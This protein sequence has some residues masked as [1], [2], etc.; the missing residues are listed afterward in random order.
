MPGRQA[1]G[2]S[3]LAQPKAK[4]GPKKSKSRAQTNALN[5]FNIAQERFPTKDKRTPRARELDAEIEKK[6]GREEDDEEDEEEEEG[7]KRKKA[8]A[9]RGAT[10]DGD[11]EFG[12]DSEG[13]EWQLGGM[14]NDD[15]DSEIES[16]DAFG[17]SDNE[18]FQGYAFRGSKSGQRK[19]D[20]SEDSDDGNDDQG[21]TLGED[22][23]DLATALDQFEEESEEEPEG[24][25]EEEDS[26]SGEE[27]DSDESDE[28]EGLDDSDEEAD[29]AKLEEL[30]GLISGFGGEEDDGE[31]A[32][33]SSGQQKIDLGDLGLSGLN[34]PFMKQSVK[35]MKK[36]SKEKRPGSTKKLEV[37][38]SR[39]EQGRIDR[40]AAYEKTN[41][42]L[43]RWTETVKQNRRAE[44]LVFPLPQNSE[45]AGLDRTELQPLSL[46][47]AANELEATIMGIME[48]S[49]LSL[50]KEKKPKKQEF[51]EEG[52]LLTRKQALEKKRIERELHSREAKRAARIKKIKS[53]AYHRVHRKQKERDEMATREAMA[54][55]G[56]IDSEE[57]REAQDRRRAL[58]R[59]GQ[60]H[61]DSKWAKMGSKAK[62]AVWDDDFRAGLTE[63]ARKDEDLRRRKEGKS[64]R[65]DGDDSDETSS[66]GSDDDDDNAD[67]LRQLD[68]L[69]K[70]DDGPQ[71]RLMKMK[72]MQKAEA[73]KKKANDDLI[74][75]IR[76][77][78]DGEGQGSDDDE[79]KGGE[80]GRRQYGSGA[81]NPF[82]M[83]Q[84]PAQATKK[85]LARDD[86]AEDGDENTSF[87][88]GDGAPH[89][90]NG[91]INHA[92]STTPA[93]TTSSIAGAWSKGESRRK[94]SARADDLDLNA[95]ILTAAPQPS[96]KPKPSKKTKQPQDDDDESESDSD[97]DS[98]IRLPMAI[99][100]KDLVARA[101][102]GE[103]V[104]AEFQREKDEVAEADDDKVIDNTLPGWGSWVGDGVSSREKKRHQGRF[105]TKVEGINKK[106][107]KDAKLDKVII[108]EKRIK[109][110]DRYLA[111][112][113]PFPFESQQQYE[114][115]LRLPVG[116]EWMT[117]ETF[118][119]ST[120]PRVIM[121]QG[122]IT[123]MSKPNA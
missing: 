8:K 104:V 120:K 69:E 2:R 48:Q 70:E 35:L 87:A 57:E 55:A 43:D 22:A 95:N 98:D 32:V 61:K 79:E 77:E 96:S 97:S 52:N 63:M 119:A 58:E 14:A 27:E 50:E 80:V 10:T 15:E 59:V 93:E 1:H 99:R 94:K 47:G 122:I 86:S 28:F 49:G 68:E 3:L 53:K 106:D 5:A 36:E 45:S 65:G 44:H 110:N 31:K 21:E 115:S 108:N 11:V 73:A 64:S 19:D 67:L 60:R 4:A 54:E 62:R 118:Q 24:E 88:N 90:S 102:A 72:F 81:V 117:K 30:K 33:S 114:R 121:K 13:N 6:H 29:P 76:K 20:D 113:L 16:D 116:P 46:K 12:S 34:D 111:A 26:E 18:M 78:L 9:P 107:R 83:P 85:K 37:P 84:K 105:L 66:S 103:D 74:K 82:S 38:L 92:W 89:I 75:E 23:I 51:D 17:D 56:E 109:K 71:S 39:R 91:S 101:F 7:P 42:T 100:D 40:S 41:E 123:P 25:E 112:Q